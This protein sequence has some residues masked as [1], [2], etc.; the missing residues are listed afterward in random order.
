MTKQERVE[1]KDTL[2]D[3]F[4]TQGCS[5]HKAIEETNVI[6]KTGYYKWLKSDEEFAARVARGKDRDEMMLDLAEDL[7]IETMKKGGAQ[8]IKA[9][10]YVLECKGK[11]RG[12]GKTTEI[13]V[14]KTERAIAEIVLADT[15]PEAIKALVENAKKKIPKSEEEVTALFDARLS[16]AEEVTIDVEPN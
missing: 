8:G 3:Y 14:E 12:W 15:S 2:I 4:Y 5:I 1:A 7:F 11:P 6:S 9:A 13:K 16:S 10:T